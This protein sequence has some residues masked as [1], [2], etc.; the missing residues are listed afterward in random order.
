MRDRIVSDIRTNGFAI[1]KNFID[2]EQSCI[3]LKEY[4]SAADKFADGVITDIPPN[5]MT[6]IN[7]KISGLIPNIANELGLS[8]DENRYSYSAIRGLPPEKWSSL[9]YSF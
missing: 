5:L 8:I 1:I 7:S 9:M 6:P 2:N 4:L 3:E